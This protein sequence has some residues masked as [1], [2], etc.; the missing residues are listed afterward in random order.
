VSARADALRPGAARPAV[1]SGRVLRERR[2]GGTTVVVRE[3]AAAP[4]VAMTLAIGVGS[5]DET[6]PTSGVSALL[7]RTLLKGTRTRT[8]LELAQAAE[9]AGGALQSATDQEYSELRARGLARAWPTLLA[10]L[11]EV[12]TAPRLAIDEVERERAGL[13]AQ[14]RALEDQ[15]FHVANRL[16]L[17]ALYG[18]HPYG[19][20][21]A[22]DPETVRRLTRDDLL[23]H[24]ARSYRP[25]RMVLSIS[26][27]VPGAEVLEAAARLFGAATPGA[28]PAP[29]PAVPERPAALRARETRP[30]EQSHLLLGYLAP[31]LRHP[32][33]PALK[34]ANAVLG[35]GMSGRLFRTLR[36]EAGLAYSVGSFYPTRGQSS[37]VV[38][39][40]GTAPRNLAEAEAGIAR[41]IGRLQDETVPEDELTRAKAF[42]TGGF[43]LDLRTNERRSF[44]L[45]FLE[46]LGTGHE[47]VERYPEAIRAVTAADVQRV[48]RGWLV[49]PATVVVGP[50]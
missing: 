17:R 2:P 13:L 22:G 46:L 33:Y 18:E 26:G 50:A 44:Y 4:V 20:P 3:N 39:H 47:Y 37:R 23:A 48:A 7:G 29:P 40:I 12:A 8:A 32:D 10:L 43:A 30:T 41:E 31:P 5:R 35:S 25:D 42:V 28:P 16:L 21:T 45:A 27:R 38:V 49:H 1:A 14:I 11:H 19:L 24:Y 15:P 9:D 34:L 6:A 36:D